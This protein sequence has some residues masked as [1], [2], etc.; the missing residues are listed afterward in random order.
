MEKTNPNDP[1]HPVG[2]WGQQTQS[3]LT[4][5]ELFAL[6]AMQALVSNSNQEIV[7]NITV[8]NGYHQP[9]RVGELA[10]GIADGLISELSK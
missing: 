5:R 2:M 9:D 4:K 10:V 1:A 6:A 8:N 3:G 7:A